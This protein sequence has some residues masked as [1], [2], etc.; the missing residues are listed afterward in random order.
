VGW[1]TEKQASFLKGFVEGAPKDR[2]V[3]L[4]MSVNGEGSL[5]CHVCDLDCRLSG[6]WKKWNDAAFFG[7]PFLWTT[8]HDFGGTDGVLAGVICFLRLSSRDERRLEPH[9]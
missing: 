6:E 2:F 3:V 1:T 5:T 8:L 9:Q 4:D 7:A